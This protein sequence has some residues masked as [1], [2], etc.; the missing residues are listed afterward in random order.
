MG[1]SALRSGITDAWFDVEILPH[2]LHLMALRHLTPSSHCICC[3]P[4]S[5][6]NVRQRFITLLHQGKLNPRTEV[7]DVV[8]SRCAARMQVRLGG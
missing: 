3:W 2:R 5:N 6:V 4:D 1:A 8:E 7:L